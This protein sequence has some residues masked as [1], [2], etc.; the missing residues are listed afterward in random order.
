MSNDTRTPTS[1]RLLF[2]LI[3]TLIVAIA[4]VAVYIVIRQVT[5]PAESVT[6]AFER[7]DDDFAGDTPIDP[8]RDMPDFTLI[9]QHDESVSLSDFT[10][11]PVLMAYGFTHCPDVC[12][13][14]LGEFKAVYEALGESSADVAFVFISVD[15]ERDTPSRL[16]RY[17]QLRQVDEF[18]V[19][20][21]GSPDEVRRIGAD[22]GIKFSYGEP[23]DNG[24]YN[25][26][27]TAGYY[28]L[29][30]EGNW[31]MRYDFGTDPALMASQ[32]R[33]MIAPSA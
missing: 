23:D 24:A 10:G 3:G 12:P 1:N 22:Y 20:L 15:G 17:L 6:V 7:V 30:A 26:D 27:H 13:I 5:A 2:T 33:E 32:I 19:G 8:P 16:S 14:T 28:L 11:K 25:V 18:V 4:I 21:T 29:D 31:I 9:N